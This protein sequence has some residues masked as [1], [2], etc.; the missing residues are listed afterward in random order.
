MYGTPCD[1]HHTVHASHL[2]KFLDKSH[3]C[4]GTH[5]L[6]RGTGAGGGEGRIFGKCYIAKTNT[7][8]KLKK[9]NTAAPHFFSTHF[10]LFGNRMKHASSRLI[11]FGI[12]VI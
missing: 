11:L 10:S 3:N 2:R 9:K 5:L 12:C 7:R 8:K 1:V 4:T 6:P